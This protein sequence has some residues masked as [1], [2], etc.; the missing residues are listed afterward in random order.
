MSAKIAE[1]MLLTSRQQAILKAI[2]EDYILTAEPVG[3]RLLA[4][5][6]GFGLS[7]ATL[8]NEMAD[9]EEGGLLRQPHTSAGRIPSD[10]GYRI[11]V[12]VLMER[13]TQVPAEEIGAL[14]RFS[15]DQRD[16]YDI[17]QQTAKVTALLAGCTAIVR[18]PRQQAARVQ[19]LQLVS[20]GADEAMVIIVTDRGGTLHRRVQLG[21]PLSEDELVRLS[22]F[23][24]HHLRGQ[25]L[26]GVTG[27]LIVELM[28]DMERYASVLQ[29]LLERITAPDAGSERVFVANASYLAEQPEFGELDKI[30]SLLSLL[31]RENALAELLTHVSSQQGEAVRV[32][33]GREIPLV[34][35][36]AC[37]VV[38]APYA[39]G[40]QVFGEIGVMGPT[41]LGYPRAI[42]AVEA[43]ARHLSHTLTRVFG[44]R[45]P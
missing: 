23:L 31:E 11:F 35:L 3:S 40:G 38:M 4:K 16:L 10:A 2:I 15:F 27:R 12:D 18:A 20:L 6:F 28:T 34:D 25:P 1:A 14:T 19:L 32:A 13:P 17:L 43:M 30:R 5:K 29:Q 33:I 7:P 8:R 39:V 42:A 22:G 37:S 44:Y 41:R 26:D 21:H 24:N 45:E 9:L 36:Q